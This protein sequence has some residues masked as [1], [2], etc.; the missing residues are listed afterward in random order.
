M[1][2][3]NNPSDTSRSTSTSSTTLPLFDTQ[4]KNH[5]QIVPEAA[6]RALPGIIADPDT[7]GWFVGSENPERGSNNLVEVIDSGQE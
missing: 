7:Q 2:D 1:P 5:E 4:G 3:N 6:A